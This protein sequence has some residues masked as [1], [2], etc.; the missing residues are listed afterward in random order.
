MPYSFALCCIEGSS[1]SRS[2]PLWGPGAQLGREQG[3]KP[4]GGSESLDL[5]PLIHALP[6]GKGLNRAL[7]F[8]LLS[9]IAP[10]PSGLLDSVPRLSHSG[11]L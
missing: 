6:S 7:Y 9:P 1:R 4:G 2:P 3:T 10:S 8:L 11:G 5:F